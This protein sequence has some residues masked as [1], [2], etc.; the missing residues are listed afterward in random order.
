MIIRKKA[1]PELFEAVLNGKKD[2]DIRL[3]EFKVNEG[4]ILLLEEWN[5]KTKKY[6]GRKIKKK[7]KFI[8]HTNQLPF[9]TE[10][11][12]LDHGFVVMGF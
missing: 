9:W 2:F 12:V 5:P 8:L 10:Q 1:W 11:E 4:D 7:I 3:D 6:T